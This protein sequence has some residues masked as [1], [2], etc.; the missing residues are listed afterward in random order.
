LAYVEMLASLETMR[1]TG[2][3]LALGV[4]D[5]QMLSRI[6]R[7]VERGGPERQLGLVGPT[8]LGALIVSAAGSLALLD[9]EIATPPADR[10]TPGIE[11]QPPSEVEAIPAPA[12]VS[13]SSRATGE[14]V[15]EAPAS[16]ASAES[17]PSAA[18]GSPS[19]ALAEPLATTTTEATPVLDSEPP[20]LPRMET[21]RLPPPSEVFERPPARELAMLERPALAAPRLP[22]PTPRRML[23]DPEPVL[24][25]GELIERIEPDYPAAARQHGV[26]GKVEVEFLVTRDGAV[27]DVR[28]IRENPKGL[29]FA[30]AARDAIGSWRFEPFRRG[31]EAVDRRVRLEVAFDLGQ[32]DRRECRRVTGSRIPRCY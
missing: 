2:P 7:L 26:E 22:E 20:A 23:P 5:G 16:G 4:H 10:T 29:E 8:L 1:S 13:T 30:G 27:R 3:R 19:T 25:G 6:R 32:R 12:S 31:G 14:T 17:G 15:V 11:R 9:E 21:E 24:A 28:V 18:A